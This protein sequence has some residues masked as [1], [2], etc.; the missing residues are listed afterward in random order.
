[1]QH[2]QIEQ[3]ELDMLF[4]AKP[5]IFKNTM[6]HQQYMNLFTQTK[7]VYL[8]S[9]L[10]IPLTYLVRVLLTKELPIHEF[11]LFM[12]I[13]GLITM[14]AVY[15]ELG[16][17][18][19][20][21]Y[22]I[23]KYFKQKKYGQIIRLFNTTTLV[24][25]ALAG[26]IIA[27]AYA[28][29]S[30]IGEYFK[31]DMN[32]L[33]N[34]I[35][36]LFFVNFFAGIIQG[37]LA[38]VQ[39]THIAS[40]ANTIRFSLIIALVILTTD[41]IQT[42]LWIYSG[43]LAIMLCAE[44]VIFSHELRKIKPRTKV[45]QTPVS[46]KKHI[47]EFK[48]PFSYALYAWL[49]SGIIILIYGLDIQFV[50]L[51]STTTDVALY[52]NA[53]A[54]AAIIVSICTPITTTLVPFLAA[55]GKNALLTQTKKQLVTLGLIVSVF[56][57]GAIFIWSTHILLI[58]FGSEYQSAHLLLKIL[59]I[60]LFFASWATIFYSIMA[61]I[62]D[63]VK[64]NTYY[65]IT[66]TINVLGNAIL[67]YY[68]STIGIAI[69]TLLS[70]ISMFAL[71]YIYVYKKIQMRIHLKQAVL[72]ICST[73]LSIYLGQYIATVIQQPIIKG[74]VGGSIATI[75]Y[76]CAIV[77]FKILTVDQIKTLLKKLLVRKID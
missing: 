76:A 45:T 61:G 36:V 37:A 63:V 47:L 8:F 22:F 48:Q 10:A 57:T 35:V 19:S 34:A 30:L 44:L 39:K 40:I 6:Y 66:A 68:F 29:R 77:Y 33:F 52:A 67:G 2:P 18:E 24:I 25:F 58:V 70:C 11:G 13:F 32:L 71:G 43:T 60:A 4:C 12:S 50:T 7:L 9:Y 53:Y 41:N 21:T 56:I 26:I 75:V 59:A 23:S 42:T 5:N 16:L 15:A 51:Y 46:F 55:N 27:T 49:S 1:V 65:A 17:S 31:A 69:A 20:T 62:G 14:F 54:L 73:I 38:G 28:F 72:I 74:L 3:N 64:R